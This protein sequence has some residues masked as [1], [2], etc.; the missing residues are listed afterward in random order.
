MIQPYS[1]A[2][3][4]FLA[5]IPQMIIANSLGVGIC[6]IVIHSRTE[7]HQILLRE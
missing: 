4:V 6:I 3:A 1:V 7:L 2:T 5:T